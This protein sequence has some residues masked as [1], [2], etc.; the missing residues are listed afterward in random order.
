MA[1]S[2][3][4][5]FIKQRAAFWSNVNHTASLR[6]W[7]QGRRKSF[8]S[9][10]VVGRVSKRSSILGPILTGSSRLWARWAS[11]K[12]ELSSIT[13]TL[14]ASCITRWIIDAKARRRV[15]IAQQAF[16]QQRRH[17]LQNPALSISRRV[18]LFKTLVWSRFCYG[19]ESWTLAEQGTKTYVHNAL[20]R[21]FRRLL[22]AKHDAHLSDDDILVETGLNSPTETASIVSPPIFGYTISLRRTSTLGLDQ[23]RCS[24]DYSAG[25]RSQLALATTTRGFYAAGSC[26]FPPRVDWSLDPPPLVL[27]A[28]DTTRRRTRNSTAS[29]STSSWKLPPQVYGSFPTDP[30]WVSLAMS[31]I[32]PE[33]ITLRR[34][35]S[36]HAWSAVAPLRAKAGLALISSKYMVF[37]RAW[38][39]YLRELAAGTAW[40]ST[41]RS[42]KLH[43]HLR[44]STLCREKL[45]GRRSRFAPTGG[46]GSISD[47]S[48]CQAHDGILPPLQ[49][50]G[51]Q[52][53]DRPAVTLPDYDLQMAET[54]YQKVLEAEGG[55]DVE[56]LV[57]SA[58]DDRITTWT[59]WRATLVYMLDILTVEDIQ[60][61]D[62]GEYDIKRLL[63]ALQH[64]HAWPF[65]QEE[66]GRTED[67]TRPLEEMEYDCAAA[68]ATAG[69]REPFWR[70]PRPMARERF[71]IHAFSGRR[72]AG[73]LQHFIEEAQAAY[74]DMVI[75]TISVDFDGGPPLGGCFRSQRWGPFGWMR[76]DRGRFVG[77]MAGPPC[78]TWSQARGQA[79]PEGLW[80]H[81]G[82][83]VV[84]DLGG[85]GPPVGAHCPRF[86][87]GS[88]I[89]CWELAAA[90]HLGAPHHAGHDGRHWRTW[91]PSTSDRSSQ[92]Q[93]MAIASDEV[94]AG[95]AGNS[96]TLR[97]RR[98]FGA[99]R[100]ASRR[101]SCF[102][103]FTRWSPLY[104]AGNWR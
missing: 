46:T 85:G 98:D 82:P 17:L 51:P 57:R 48:L 71:F 70:I 1:L 104:A 102:W 53:E 74:P 43:A 73:D 97:F 76:C 33:G 27:E 8:W 5:R 35:T 26:A 54:I 58:T 47:R 80:K 18:E 16:S 23:Q 50:E 20:M 30:T 32:N 12:F 38:G 11:N 49:A 39:C 83:R 92:G 21:L 40:R 4:T 86:E 41:T 29:S 103:I 24:V 59:I 79:L 64:A 34:R 100:A 66:L 22:R 25:W 52:P 101:G 15:G 65:L 36:M 93:Y 9:F 89:G 28:T 60:A 56:H 69:A 37:R 62:I 2:W 13:H 6:T 7:V 91:T 95:M 90:L 87:G 63:H 77:A 75:F 19:T 88:P 3:S 31:N 10:K 96:S 99:H 42:A 61:L 55:A 78:E 84:R 44:H 67:R 68:A 45:W 94:L 14:A 81:R 72:R